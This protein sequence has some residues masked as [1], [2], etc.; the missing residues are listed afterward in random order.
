[1]LHS[2]RSAEYFHFSLIA[3]VAVYLIYPLLGPGYFVGHE[4]LGPQ[5]RT[6]GIA[7]AVASG[8]FPA[9]VLPNLVNGFGYGWSIFYP[10]LTYDL[11]WLLSAAGFSYTNSVKLVHFLA[12]ML[13][14]VFT[15]ALMVR[16]TGRRDAA[17]LAAVLYMTAPYRLVDLYIRNAYAESFAFVFLPIVFLGVY[18]IFHGQARRW[19]ILALG[20]S[21]AVLTHSI[22]AL[23]CATFVA[24]YTLTQAPRVLREPAGPLRSLGLATSMSMLLT[25]YFTGPLLE[26]KLGGNYGIFDR[27]FAQ[28]IGISADH[29]RDHA[30]KPLQLFGHEINKIPSQPASSD[31]AEMPF[32]LGIPLALF[33]IIGCVMAWRLPAR[34][35]FVFCAVT[36]AVL[37]LMTLGG[38]IW[39]WLPE[40]YLVIQYPWRLLLFVAFF[41]SLIGGATICAIPE[42]NAKSVY[43]GF[44]ILVPCVYSLL[45][46]KPDYRD[47]IDD[48]RIPPVEDVRKDTSN[49]GTGLGEYLPVASLAYLSYL[50]SRGSE[51]TVMSGTAHLSG[52]QH[53]GTRAKLNVEVG[54]AAA[55][56]ELPFIHYLGY[57]AT[58]RDLTGA[59][60]SVDVSEGLN[61]FSVVN[62]SGSGVLE[63]WYGVTTWSAIAYGT[64]I[65]GFAWLILLLSRQNGLLVF[66]K[67][68]KRSSVSNLL[69]NNAINV[70]QQR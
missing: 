26:H 40:T 6:F 65:V 17:L 4:G 2:G 63:V 59:T 56:I 37:L 13:S 27:G 21:G 1:M 36:A 55:L 48:S 54:S 18:E 9:K 61:G 39:S 8:Q 10:P 24:V 22:T 20:M 50:R 45:F 3:A 68:A 33:A 19:W 11:T 66:G 44:L 41:L 30:L 7:Q 28:A 32:P 35:F 14:G 60:R 57:K 42:R 12:I 52:F 69:V 15:Y 70:R 47:F 43:V 31:G 58:M 23:Y 67:F 51:P 38:P 25:V 34:G 5:Y 62:V 64:N 53:V 29:V 16:V 46:I 49:I